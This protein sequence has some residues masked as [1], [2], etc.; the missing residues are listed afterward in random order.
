M[1]ARR[2]GRTV[3]PY[4]LITPAIVLIVYFKIYPICNTFL[5]S[6]TYDGSLSLGNFSTLFGDKYFWDSLLVTVKFN[7]IL[8]PLQIFLALLVSLLVNADVRGI[9]A[10]RTIFYL[11][12]TMSTAV[13]AI[14]WNTMLNPN[15][16]VINSL[17]GMLQIPP[18]PFLTSSSQAIYCIMLIT[19]WIGVGYWMMF[20]LA[21]LKN[22]DRAVYES[23]RVDGAGW[24]TI[25]LK[26]TIPMIRRTLAFVLIADTTINL[27]M[28]APMQIITSGGPQRSTAV[29]MYE[30]YKSYFLYVDKGRGDAIVAVLLLIIAFVCAVQFLLINDR[31]EKPGKAGKGGAGC[32]K[33]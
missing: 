23:A 31:G 4:I 9:G 33:V 5:D 11:P 14:I 17:L 1:K 26:I 22:V 20:L 29:L 6:L 19:T 12:A 25:T 7:L 3:L 24:L 16:G 21:G 32:E 10:F 18:Q 28:F 13:A 27:L 8:T 2:I 30:A 15:S